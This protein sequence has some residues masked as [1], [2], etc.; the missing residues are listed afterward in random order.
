MWRY[1][2][3]VPIVALLYFPLYMTLFG[4]AYGNGESARPDPLIGVLTGIPLVALNFPLMYLLDL[5]VPLG[6]SVPY[7]AVLF[8]IRM[9]GILWGLGITW[10]AGKLWRRINYRSPRQQN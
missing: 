8:L 7:E 10:S 6:I 2:I 5:S 4:I 9:N 1:L 3:G